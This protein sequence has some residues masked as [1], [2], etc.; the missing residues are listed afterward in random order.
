MKLHLGCG[1]NNIKGYVNIDVRL[2]NGVDI[3]DDVK[4][5]S[6]YA[7]S[8]VEVIYASH[9]LEHIGRHEYKD[10]LA[11]WHKILQPNGILRLSVPDMEKVFLHYAQFKDLEKLKG[12]IWGGQNYRYNYHYIGWDFETLKK[13]L[14]DTGFTHIQR[15]DWR[16]TEHA[17]MDDYS[18]CY[19]P[20][21]DKENGEI[22]SLNIE[23]IK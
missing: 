1:N 9:V 18:Q 20:H 2:L 13:D 16:N 22:M 7:D 6:S 14:S 15:Y 11:R 19:L 21:L 23:A 8:S 12:F 4:T 5:L 3:V 10:V 17:D